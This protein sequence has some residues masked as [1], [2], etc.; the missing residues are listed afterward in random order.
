MIRKKVFFDIA[1]IDNLSEVVKSFEALC[2][3]GPKMISVYELE[4]TLIKKMANHKSNLNVFG[5]SASMHMKDDECMKH[6]G[7][8]IDAHIVRFADNLVK[9]N[10][11]G[12][13]CSFEQAYILRSNNSFNNLLTMCPLR[14][15]DPREMI[16][17]GIDYLI[18]G[19][20]RIL[21][22]R[23]F[24]ILEKE[25]ALGLCDRKLKEAHHELRS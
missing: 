8:K 14:Y 11:L 25:I 12:V 1:F 9:M 4:D 16:G 22:I 23:S 21:D 20:E 24:Q 7:T 2:I 3:L 18:V 19:D 6:F 5:K 10:F 13:V 17:N 15:K